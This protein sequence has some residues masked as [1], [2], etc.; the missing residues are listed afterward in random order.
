MEATSVEL[1]LQGLSNTGLKWH[2]RMRSI[3]DVTGDDKRLINRLEEYDRNRHGNVEGL[4]ITLAGDRVMLLP[5][6]LGKIGPNYYMIVPTESMSLESCFSKS[7]EPMI[8]ISATK[9]YSTKL[10]SLSGKK[11]GNLSTQML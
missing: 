4:L 9:P 1:W 11:A 8:K 6:P 7:W 5:R 3:A 10:F 2:L